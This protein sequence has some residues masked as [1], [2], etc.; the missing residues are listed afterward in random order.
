MD[1]GGHMMGKCKECHYHFN[2]G[3]DK[4]LFF[5]IEIR[6]EIIQCRHFHP[7][8]HFVTYCIKKDGEV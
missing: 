8:D 3:K 7:K 5:E 2:D 4:C 6:G 1:G